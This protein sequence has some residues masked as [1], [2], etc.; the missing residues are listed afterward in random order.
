[1][2]R[3]RCGET[4]ACEILSAIRPSWCMQALVDLIRTRDL[5]RVE[6]QFAWCELVRQ[7]GRKN[8]SSCRCIKTFGFISS[9]VG[10][11]HLLKSLQIFQDV[12]DVLLASFAYRVKTYLGAVH[13]TCRYLRHIPE[14]R[15]RYSAVES[16]LEQQYDVVLRTRILQ[17]LKWAQKGRLKLR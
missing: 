2:S 7:T 15:E 9:R 8:P 6:L 1:M 3:T 17:N 5:A 14:A 13:F 16:Q 4:D 12:S 11:R 10:V